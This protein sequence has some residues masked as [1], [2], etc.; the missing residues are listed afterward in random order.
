MAP[1]AQVQGFCAWTRD[2]GW[3]ALDTRSGLVTRAPAR[4]REVRARTG[5][6]GWSSGLSRCFTANPVSGCRMSHQPF[7]AFRGHF[8]GFFGLSGSTLAAAETL[9]RAFLAVETKRVTF[10][11]FTP[12]D[13]IGIS[14]APRRPGYLFNPFMLPHFLPPRDPLAVLGPFPPDGG[15]PP[16]RCPAWHPIGM[17]PGAGRG[18]AADG[19]D[20]AGCLTAIRW[21]ARRERS[22]PKTGSAREGRGRL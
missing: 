16:P 9:A 20:P 12:S 18:D 4:A 21:R 11:I 1:P 19:N 17:G 13:G 10:S 2:R 6:S 5:V 22:G 8:S 14:A 7:G 3:L 15:N